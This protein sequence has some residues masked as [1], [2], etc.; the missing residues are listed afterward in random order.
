[1]GRKLI[2]D[3]EVWLGKKTMIRRCDGKLVPV[4]VKKDSRT[5][6]NCI[7]LFQAKGICHGTGAFCKARHDKY[8]GE[9]EVISDFGCS[10]Q[11][12]LSNDIFINI[13]A[14]GDEKTDTS[15]EWGLDFYMAQDGGPSPGVRGLLVPYPETDSCRRRFYPADVIIQPGQNW[16]VRLS[17]G[18]ITFNKSPAPHEKI[19]R[20]YVEYTLYDGSVAN[21]V[22]KIMDRGEYVTALAVESE[23]RKNPKKY[24]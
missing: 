6:F 4:T 24:R 5:G 21:A 7:N 23:I 12:G 10:P 9:Y 14:G 13:R 3:F 18:D 19:I 8:P 20:A 17:Y 16:E 2:E 15:K 11:V 22:K 1:M